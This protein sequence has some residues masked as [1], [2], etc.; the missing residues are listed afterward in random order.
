MTLFNRRICRPWG[1]R[2][3]GSSNSRGPKGGAKRK[4][5]HNAGK[6]DDRCLD[7][8]KGV[9]RNLLKPAAP[10]P[11][12]GRTVVCFEDMPELTWTVILPSSPFAA[13]S[14]STTASLSSGPSGPSLSNV[15]SNP[16]RAHC[17]NCRCHIFECRAKF[18]LREK[19]L[20]GSYSEGFASLFDGEVEAVVTVHPLCSPPHLPVTNVLMHLLDKQVFIC[21]AERENQT[22]RP[23]VGVFFFLL[24]VILF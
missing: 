5:S 22:F 14:S 9:K 16:L 7:P 4:P 15:K 3:R 8:N 18:S 21:R 2:S 23:F 17:V 20:I 12:T 1:P 13:T 10:R 6:A 24:N 11:P 19:R